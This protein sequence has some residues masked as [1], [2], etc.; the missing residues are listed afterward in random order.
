MT[1]AGEY[2]SPSVIV[3]LSDDSLLPALPME[4]PPASRSK[5]LREKMTI[6]NHDAFEPLQAKLPILLTL[7]VGLLMAVKYHLLSAAK[8]FSPLVPSLPF[9]LMRDIIMCP[10]TNGVSLL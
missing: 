3:P 1:I 8:L 6:P 7:D 4:P 5:K 9:N 10:Q 2:S